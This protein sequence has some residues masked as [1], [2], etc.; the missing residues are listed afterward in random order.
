[1][2]EI[3]DLVVA[4]GTV[5]ALDGVNISV[6]EGKITAGNRPEPATGAVLRLE[7]PCTTAPTSR[8]SRA[9]R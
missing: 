1:M 2:L 4:Y 6:P 9:K 3:K 8:H 5:K 7:L